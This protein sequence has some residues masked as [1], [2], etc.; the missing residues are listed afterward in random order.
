M[1]QIIQEDVRVTALNEIEAA[2]SVVEAINSSMMEGNSFFILSNAKEGRTAA[3]VQVDSKDL[4][5]LH[6]ILTGQRSRLIKEI[7]AKAARHRIS[8]DPGDLACLE[9]KVVK[10][11]VR[12]SKSPPGPDNDF[13]GESPDDRSDAETEPSQDEDEPSQ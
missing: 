9:G 5:K 11:R 8:L 12:A 3:K 1:P 7:H 10:K 6:S 13:I 2:L 4:P